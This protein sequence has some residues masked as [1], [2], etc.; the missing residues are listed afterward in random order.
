VA[1]AGRDPRLRVAA[2]GARSARLL[3]TLR[4]RPDIA[5]VE[6]PEADVVL[7]E[8]AGMWALPTVLV[9]DEG[10]S[11]RDDA[12]SVV[13]PDADGATLA[14]AL[15]LA[16]SGYRVRPPGRGSG[17]AAAGAAQSELTPR[18]QAVL[19]LLADGASNKL[20]ARRLGIS[21]STAKF[22]VAS[23]I[24]KLGARNRLDAVTI[25]MRRGL[26]LV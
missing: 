18:E 21:P 14:A 24:D 8:E 22:H 4:A 25:G 10:E 6:W 1:E 23:L 16:A 12:A 9:E 11:R 13:R 7:A 17:L 15:R 2:V 20:I 19:A 26:V 5:V 3:A